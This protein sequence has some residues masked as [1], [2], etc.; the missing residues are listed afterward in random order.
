MASTNFVDNSTVIYA[1]WLNDVNNAVYNGIFAAS[2]IS[3]ANLVCNGS[4]SGSGFTGLVNNTLSAP[5]AIGSATPNTGAFTTLTLTNKLAVAQGGTGLATLTANNVIL[6][7]GTSTPTFVAPGASGNVLTSNGTTWAST[8][9]SGLAKAW[10]SFNA[11]GTILKAYNVSSI[12]VRGTGQWT[13]NFTNALAD[14]NYVM[15]GNAAY[16]PTYTNSGGVFVSFNWDGTNGTAPTTTSCQINTVRGT[17]T[18][19]D[20][21]YFNP[22][23]TTVVFFD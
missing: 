13:I 9:G 3:P 8:N 16:G 20:A 17:Y 22:A 21:V 4:V 18:G 19:S 15:A 5:G 12:T 14:G 6:G 2:S 10:V 1:A 7:N 11:S 23:L